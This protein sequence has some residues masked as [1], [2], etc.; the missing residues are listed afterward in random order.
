M[1]LLIIFSPFSLLRE[2]RI[3]CQT[4]RDEARMKILF[5]FSKLSILSKSSILQIRNFARLNAAEKINTRKWFRDAAA[6]RMHGVAA[7]II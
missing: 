4:E 7:T 2:I 6:I 3:Y 5:F 1:F